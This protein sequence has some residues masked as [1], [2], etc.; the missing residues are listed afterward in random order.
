MRNC[1]T[2]SLVGK[3]AR[4]VLAW[5]IVVV[6]P[7]IPVAPAVGQ[8]AAPGAGRF[9]TPAAQPVPRDGAANA[10]APQAPLRQPAAPSAARPAGSA[11]VGGG[12]PAAG[13]RTAQIPGGGVPQG[14]G[15]PGGAAQPPQIAPPA[16]HPLPPAEQQVVNQI[17]AAW[18]KQ[19]AQIKTFKAN[20]VRWEY[21]PV[22]GKPNMPYFIT[23]GEVRFASPDKG[24][25]QELKK[26]YAQPTENPTDTPKYLPRQLPD[27]QDESGDHWVCTGSAVFHYEPTQKVL[28]KTMLPAEMQ[29]QAIADGPL[30]FVFSA[31]AAKLQQRYWIRQLPP[32]EKSDDVMLEFVPRFPDDLQNF[33]RAEVALSR[34][35]VLPV[36]LRLDRLQQ[37]VGTSYTRWQIK[38]AEVNSMTNR[39]QA[40]MASFV[41]P[42]L[43]K[44]WREVTEDY[45]Q[46]AAE[47]QQPPQNAGLPASGPTQ[48]K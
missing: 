35:D 1:W 38:D 32:R 7:A 40:W 26:G 42:K 19:N 13:P 4:L 8:Q 44:G 29:G 6:A 11:P 18:E 22:L 21:D 47:V 31:K 39:M 17:L 12:A 9:N 3:H 2:W 36:M 30:P 23:T 10:A 5:S 20:F 41:Q 34:K 14:P 45:R 43:P 27:G 33:I 24:L 15:T 16:W 46:P 25:Y 37:N 28:V 48:R